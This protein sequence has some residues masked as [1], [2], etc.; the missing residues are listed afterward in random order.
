ME[1]EA[2]A[3]EQALKWKREQEEKQ[4]KLREAEQA[5]EEA[6]KQAK[7]WSKQNG[8]LKDVVE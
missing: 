4:Q 5:E 8:V 1:A 6:K 2:H 3:A 7:L